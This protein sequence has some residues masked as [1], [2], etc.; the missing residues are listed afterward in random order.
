MPASSKYKQIIYLLGTTACGKTTT[1]EAMRYLY[2]ADV[3]NADKFYDFAG[4]IYDRFDYDQLTLKSE[5]EKYPDMDEWKKKWYRYQ[6]GGMMKTANRTLVVE[7]ATPGFK[8]ERDIVESMVSAP[9]TTLL[10]EPN[11]WEEMY[12]KK[13]HLRPAR[14]MLDEYRNSI[15]TDYILIHDIDELLKPLDYQRLGFTDKKYEA[16]RLGNVYGKSMLDL[17]CSAGWF[18]MYATRDGIGNYVG[19]D[20]YWKNIIKARSDHYGD[21][22]L[23]DIEHY[24]DGHRDEHDIVIMAS[25]LHYFDDKEKIIKKASKRTKEVF[26]LEVPISKDNHD[27]N[28]YLVNGQTYTIP[29]QELVVEWLN[30]YFD[31]VDIV[32]QS[33]PPDGSY[34]LV[35]KGWK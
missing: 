28:E 18:N 19:V 13:H 23:D 5:Q 22:V 3:I 32:G 7:G 24:L 33:V 12:S 10:L 25:V 20:N 29:T 8:D 17:G 11:N 31:K 15:D 27:L 14:N 1:A 4:I 16:L 6:L 21:Y 9:V 26:V 35:F 34:R 2:L 30:K